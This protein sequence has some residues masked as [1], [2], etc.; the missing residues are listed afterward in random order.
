MVALFPCIVLVLCTPRLGCTFNDQQTIAK[1]R[2]THQECTR[3]YA[4]AFLHFEP[5]VPIRAFPVQPWS[6]DMPIDELPN[7]RRF[8]AVGD[9][10]IFGHCVQDVRYNPVWGLLQMQP[11]QHPGGG[12]SAGPRTPTT[13]PPPLGAFSQQ[14]VAKGVAP[15]RPWAPKAPDAP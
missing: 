7:R 14:L 13:P 8:T 1:S 4:R 12:D 2:T 9:Q 11:G 3:K 5:R 6:A 15:R 10:Q